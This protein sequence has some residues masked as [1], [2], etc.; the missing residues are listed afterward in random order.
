MP[1]YSTRASK[2]DSSIEVELSSEK[3]ELDSLIDSLI[4]SSWSMCLGVVVT[5]STVARDAVK[6]VILICL[7]SAGCAICLF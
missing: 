6:K 1:S 3:L 5:G 2:D 7:V 4:D